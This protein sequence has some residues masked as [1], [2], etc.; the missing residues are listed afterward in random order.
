MKW[1]M[2]YGVG[3]DDNPPGRGSGRY[4]KGSGSKPRQRERIATEKRL[5]QKDDINLAQFKN[6]INELQSLGVKIDSDKNLYIPKGTIVARTTTTKNETQDKRSYVS[7][8]KKDKD[9]YSGQDFT[10]W[11]LDSGGYNVESIYV[12]EYKLKK[13]IK[14][15][16]NIFLFEVFNK[17]KNKKINKI[18][19]KNNISSIKEGSKAYKIVDDLVKKIDNDILKNGPFSQEISKKFD[20]AIDVNDSFIDGSYASLP[21]VIFNPKKTM[22]TKISSKKIWD[23]NKGYTY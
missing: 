19:K 16:N 7:F 13:E 22:G 20:G 11:F 8:L 9:V 17:N 4:P 10:E 12:N 6:N 5:I 2:H 21:L 15:A 14:V 1:L 23:S 3:P 18:L